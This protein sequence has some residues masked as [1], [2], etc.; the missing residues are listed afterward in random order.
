MKRFIATL[1]AVTLMVTVLAIPDVFAGSA[2]VSISGFGTVEPGKKYTYTVTLTVKSSFVSTGK[3]SCSGIFSGQSVDL[4]YDSST[5]ANA[6]GST[7]KSIIVTVS[8]DAKPGDT[9]KII[10]K[11]S[12]S[13]INASYDITPYTYSGSKTVNVAAATSTPSSTRKPST[14]PTARPTAKPSAKPSPTV[15]QPAVSPSPTASSTLDWAGV[16]DMVADLQEKGTLEVNMEDKPEIPVSVLAALMERDGVLEINFGSYTCTIDG[17]YLAHFSESITA[18]DLGLSMEKNQALSDAAGGN[19]V[20]QLHFSH[21]GQLPGKFTYKIKATA[22]KPGDTVYLYYYYDQA[23]VI[24][25]KQA[26]VVDQ[27]GYISFDIYHCS[28]YFISDKI[29]AG[30]VG[31]LAS[32]NTDSKNIQAE[33][34]PPVIQQTGIPIEMLLLSVLAAIV[35]S[36]LGTMFFCKSGIFRKKKE[37]AHSAPEK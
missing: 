33:N 21:E 6:N 22:S 31:S 5:G 19:D 15:S 24:E 28:D 35:V 11:G 32:I 7:T 8:K 1:L 12:G 23:G 30:A 26:C 34:V 36:A 9:G 13:S 27:D 10:V 2:S 16:E 17:Q 14:K 20:Y 18:Y 25:G 4:S 3:I 29:V 37:G